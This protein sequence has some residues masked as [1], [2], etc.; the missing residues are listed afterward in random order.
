MHS[1]QS[2]LKFLLVV[3]KKTDL[4]LFEKRATVVHVYILLLTGTLVVQLD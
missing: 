3:F 4:N 1:H 2:Q